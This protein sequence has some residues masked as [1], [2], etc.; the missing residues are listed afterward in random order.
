MTNVN[1]DNNITGYIY[2]FKVTKNMIKDKNSL[3]YKCNKEMIP[4]NIIEVKY[5][6][7][8]KYYEVRND[9]SYSYKR[10]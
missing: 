10:N 3:Q 8:M 6:D 7:F 4:D 2:V 5:K 1:I 9:N